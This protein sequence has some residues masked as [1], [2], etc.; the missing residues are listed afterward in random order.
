M[1]YGR[2]L[3]FWSFI[4]ALL[5]FA[6]GAGVSLYRGIRHARQ[7][8]PISLRIRRLHPEVVALFVKPQTHRAFRESVHRR[9]GEPPETG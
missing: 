3:Y 8:R 1:G 5:V 4:V 7:P 6:L 9:A 2:E